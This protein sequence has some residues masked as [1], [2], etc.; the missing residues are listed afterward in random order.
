MDE[1]KH[2]LNETSQAQ[3]ASAEVRHLA[4][5]IYAAAERLKHRRRE[6]IQM[7]LFA[8]C[9]VLFL[10]LCGWAMQDLLTQG[11]PSQGPLIALGALAAGAVLTLLLSPIL[12]YFTEE[13]SQ[14]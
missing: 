4:P 1:L 5:E 9:A 11:K 12:A 13:D 7:A 14:S 8:L 3:D 10:A 2:L 6:H